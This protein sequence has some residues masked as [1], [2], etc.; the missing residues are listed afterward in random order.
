MLALLWLIILFLVIALVQ[1][2]D[3]MRRLE[4]T[5]GELRHLM[6][7]LTRRVEEGTPAAPP[8]RSHDVP[9]LQTY[10][11]PPP[12][13][14]PVAASTS[15]QRAAIPGA[16]AAASHAA[17]ES[18]GRVTKKPTPVFPPIT[19]PP[20]LPPRPPRGATPEP[21]RPKRSFDWES[22]IGVKFFAIVAAIA[23]F[24]AGTFFVSYSVE[25]GWLTPPIQFAIGIV[26][27]V[28]CLVVGE[29]KV[30]RRYEWTADA[31]D[32][33]GI[34][35][36]YVV[37]FAAFAR[38]QLVGATAAFALFI[39][40]TIVA[41]LLSIRRASLLIALLGLIGGFASPAIIATGVDNPIGLF[42]Y[43]LLLN[44][45]LAWVAYKK[46]WPLLTAI[47]LGLTTMYQWG[48]VSKFLT[49]GKV[50][51][52]VGIFLVFPVLS[53]VALALN[54]PASEERRSTNALFAHAARVGAVLPLLFS[55][56]LATVPAYGARFGVLFGFLFILD[57]GLFAI[58]VFQGPR[59]LHLLGGLSTL[60]V[61]AVWL[62]GSYDPTAWPKILVAAGAFSL[63]YLGAPLV[64]SLEA[65]RRRTGVID[66]GLAAR[67]VLAAPLL[68]FVFPALALVE[69]RTASPG[70]LFAVLLALVGACA[71]YA[72]VRRDGP[73][74]FIAA[75]FAV[76]AEAVWSA[77]YL[78]PDRL[79]A[80]LAI[81]GVFGLLFIGVPIVARRRGAALAPE[82]AGSALAL[83]S[84]ALLFF[85]A[86][87][88]AAQAAL[89]GIGLL[90][91]ILTLGLFAEA[92]ATRNPVLAIIGTML[93]WAVLAAWWVT[94]TVAVALIPA[95]F[96][97]GGY[98]LLTIGGS[99]WATRRQAVDDNTRG[100]FQNGGFVA[101]A[102]HL[103]LLF[104]AT[105]P[106]LALPPWPLFAVLGVLTAAAGVGGLYV[107]RGELFLAASIASAAVLIVWEM[108]PQGA[109]WPT[110]AIFAAAA[111]VTL[112]ALW[113]TLALRIG[114][115]RRE[116]ITAAAA[117]AL[118]AQVV[119]AIAGGRT[120]V[121]PFGIV[122]G[123]QL[124]FLAVTL[125]FATLDLARLEV[126][127]L[128]AVIPASGAGF[129]WMSTHV[130]AGSWQSQL[131]FTTPIYLAFVAYPLILGRRAGLARI[132][133]LATVAASVLYFFQ[134]RMSIDTGGYGSVIGALPVV[135]AGFLALVLAHL[136]R[137]ERRGE[138]R[139]R[140]ELARLALVAGAA[141]GFIT[142]A[143]PLQLERNW[144]T[145]GWA[146]E[147]AALA[148]LYGRIPHKGLLLF[149][150]GL[151]AVVFVRLALN[152]EVLHYVPRGAIRIWN[153]YLYTYL[154]SAAAFLVGGRVLL[155]TDDKV[156]PWLPR[157]S[158]LLPSGTVILLFLLLNI[159][160]AD[161]FATGPTITFD[162]FSSALAQDLAYTLGWAL[163]AVALLGAGIIV[164]SKP[165][166]FAAIMLL[167]IA[168]LKCAFNDLWRLGGL[169][170]VGSLV[171]IAFCAL[172]ITVALQRFVL[173]SRAKPSEAVS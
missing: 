64:A 54:R 53:F 163:F 84:I 19:P 49:A 138:P 7:R 117:A 18:V 2:R 169:Y 10:Q 144:I 166:R 104:V 93:A 42:G 132:P 95:L 14:E 65:V 153:W 38:W 160:I 21:A 73:V 111:L 11:P 94:A 85:L 29:L 83:V 79:L 131:A 154:I 123:A 4:D 52:A 47:S 96:I 76:L 77:K 135:E 106:T 143:I 145:I 122:L 23:L 119:A 87:G 92:S 133:Y 70:P 113:F 45:G 91:A 134:A 97:V 165:G 51:L 150:L 102:G 66:L 146:L 172:L 171:G 164:H 48:W 105:Q 159:E 59:V 71:T 13:P 62:Q 33:A 90:L 78:S 167:I 147:G 61:F 60:I 67:G 112:V 116:F 22:L 141:L 32:A 149:A 114:A 41:V 168:M 121:P 109:P 20:A 68:L 152:T 44:A 103:F 100:I 107:K 99:I 136:I 26:A 139:S 110:I 12:R 69:P 137:L 31:L 25:H 126:M 15:P 101:L 130:G 80:A 55:I 98:A 125:G 127:T 120:A 56:Y 72:I 16:P 30:S 74:H 118:G 156:L 148:W 128:V 34:S 6:E 155:K 46:Q 5:I 88:A 89:W 108:T 129:L 142:L 35:L 162:F 157:V 115:D 82:G 158:S 37:F 28:V 43:L 81:Y 36:L 8:A 57:A 1:V 50:P 24:L 40:A 75:F 63:F 173:G 3:R 161:Y 170:R 27:A 17:R 86:A 9:P 39:L 140:A 151:F 124:V 58:A